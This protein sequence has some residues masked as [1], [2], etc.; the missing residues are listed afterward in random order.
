MWIT[1]FYVHVHAFV[2]FSY[3]VYVVDENDTV[4]EDG[5]TDPLGNDSILEDDKD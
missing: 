3:E 2:S 1:K 4:G 5:M